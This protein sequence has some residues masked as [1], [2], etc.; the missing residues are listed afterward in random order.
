ML[1]K[2]EICLRL[3]IFQ[4]ITGTFDDYNWDWSLHHVSQK[5]LGQKLK[6]LL[7]K[8]PRVFHVGEW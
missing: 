1:L 4:K 2:N 8:A 7:V 5:C 6:V 3:K